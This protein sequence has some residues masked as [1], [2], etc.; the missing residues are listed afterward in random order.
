MAPP[1]IA[2]DAPAAHA[3]A[4]ESSAR[5]WSVCRCASAK[6]A[7]GRMP[8][9][10]LRGA[11]L[12]LVR[13]AAPGPRMPGDHSEIASRRERTHSGLAA[14]LKRTSAERR[15][16]RC[17][18]PRAARRRCPPLRSR[19]SPSRAQIRAVGLE[20]KL[21]RGCARSRDAVDQNGER[22]D[23]AGD[24]ER[25]R[26]RLA[27]RL[28]RRSS[29]APSGGNRICSLA[30]ASPARSPGAKCLSGGGS[31]AFV[32][33]STPAGARGSG[34]WRR[35]Q[36]GESVEQDRRRRGAPDQAAAPARHPAGRPRRRS[37]ACRR[38]RP[39]RRRGSRSWCRS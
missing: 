26:S 34:R 11:A 35:R 25:H 22:R 32:V 9:Q 38:S 30:C 27:H 17:R 12:L 37:C 4:P 7:A 14:G 6:S 24:F 8:G 16:G 33:T 20:E 13:H 28:A 39:T 23:R 15:H 36:T 29:R 18:R 3:R 19:R 5:D 2:A 1:P 10:T 21:P 31:L